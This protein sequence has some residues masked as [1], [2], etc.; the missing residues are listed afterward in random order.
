M[1]KLKIL[2]EINIKI[3]KSIDEL[4]TQIF[5]KKINNINN[6]FIINYNQKNNN[7]K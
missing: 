2:K 5:M 7:L 4:E 3:K 1:E 6:E